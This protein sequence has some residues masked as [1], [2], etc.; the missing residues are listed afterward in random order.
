MY[1]WGW[2]VEWYLLILL[3]KNEVGSGQGLRGVHS[4]AFGEHHHRNAMFR[5]LCRFFKLPQVLKRGNVARFFR[6]N[7][8]SSSSMEQL[9]LAMQRNAFRKIFTTHN[10][11]TSFSHI[12]SDTMLLESK[13]HRT[14]SHAKPISRGV[15][16]LYRLH[17]PALTSK[18]L[19]L[20]RSRT[21]CWS[22]RQ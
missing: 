17:A 13:T 20:G 4:E 5:C 11:L 18:M 22:L 8:W 3:Y 9:H 19:R 12:H 1:G 21:W 6:E 10:W 16:L 7:Q 14:K 15:T 2:K